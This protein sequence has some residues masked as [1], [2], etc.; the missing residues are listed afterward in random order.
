MT[1]TPLGRRA[2]GSLLLATAGAVVVR[3]GF[4]LGATDDPPAPLRTVNVSSSTQLNAALSNAQPGDHIVLANATYT[5]NRTLSRAGTAQAPIVVK[6]ASKHGAVISGGTITLAGAFTGVYGLQFTGS[7]LS[8][9][10]AADDTFVLRNWFRGPKAVRLTT[11]KRVRVGYNRFTGGPQSNLGG[12]HHI[13]VEIPNGPNLPEGGRIYRNDMTSPSGSGASGEYM[14]VYIGDA[15]GREEDVTPSF[16]DFRVEYN[17]ISDT[18]RRRGIYTKRGGQVLFN[19]IVAKGQG[20]T[21][22]RHGGRGT[23]SGNRCTNIDSVII[24]GPDHQVR[25]NYVRSRRGLVLECERVTSDG[26]R[27]NAAHRA[28][29]VGNDANVVTVGHSESGDTLVAP[30]DGVQ[31]YNHVGSV[32]LRHQTNTNWVQ[33][34]RPDMTYPAPI[35]LSPGQ[36]GPDAP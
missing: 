22:I 14:H 28:V 29:L 24:N 11:Q 4:G 9:Q 10:C 34:P 36:V 6:A 27:Y 12:G 21:G 15:G 30:V 5:G 2:F 17:R 13:Y 35:T 25:G 20:V 32:V 8:V 1:T 31:I 16:Q 3:P 7:T 18:V 19:H 33:A 26:I 23:V